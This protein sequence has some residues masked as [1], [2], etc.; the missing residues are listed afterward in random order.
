MQKT[1]EISIYVVYNDQEVGK[2]GGKW[3]KIIIIVETGRK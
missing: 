2:S 3:G 1:I